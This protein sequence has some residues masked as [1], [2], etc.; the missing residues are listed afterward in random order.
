MAKAEEPFSDH[1]K[2]DDHSNSSKTDSW[3]SRLQNSYSWKTVKDV[4]TIIGVLFGIYVGWVTIKPPLDNNSQTPN[5]LDKAIL[6]TSNAVDLEDKPL[7]GEK[8][9]EMDQPVCNVLAAYPQARYVDVPHLNVRES[10]PTLGILASP[11][12]S[13]SFGTLVLEEKSS[14]TRWGLPGGTDWFEI[15]Y[16][17]DQ[18]HEKIG[19]ISSKTE[20]G[21]PTLRK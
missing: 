6:K 11:I 1:S 21:K 18:N 3:S 17:D 4:L 9:P 15:K 19:W 5:S 10:A 16:C 20:Q 13:I 2:D 8:K 7:T 14:N 12:D